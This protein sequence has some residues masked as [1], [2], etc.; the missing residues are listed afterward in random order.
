VPRLGGID[1]LTVSGSPQGGVLNIR[2]ATLYPFQM[3]SFG[4]VAK[5]GP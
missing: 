2:L 4:E 5:A 3:E 1:P